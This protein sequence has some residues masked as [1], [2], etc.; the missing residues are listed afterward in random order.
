[1]VTDD[2]RR[3]TCP[4]LRR[5][6]PSTPRFFSLSESAPIDGPDYRADVDKG[7]FVR[8]IT[9]AQSD[10]A[11]IIEGVSD[12]RL[13]EV[14]VDEWTAK[15]VLAHLAWWQEHSARLTEDFSA[16]REPDEMT[17]PGTTTDEINDY[18]YR[19]HLSDT[20]EVTRL[21]F[22]QSFQRLLAAL[23]PLSDDDLFGRDRCPWLNGGA[24]SEMILGD[25]S[26]HYRQHMANLEPL[27][28]RGSR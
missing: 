9:S 21:A 8:T 6:R 12:D 10:I 22:T 26:L 17:H 28:E 3:T 14:V 18:V 15:D 23:E 4:R 24:L 1:V 25:S 11:H 13:L 19:Q 20:S 27:S 5:T 2:G 16:M 7:E